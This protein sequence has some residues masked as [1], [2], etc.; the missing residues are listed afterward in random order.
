MG[1]RIQKIETWFS[2]IGKKLISGVNFAGFTALIFLSALYY[3]KNSWSKRHE[4][5]LQMYNAGVKTFPVVS[6]VAL[7]TGM[8]LALQLGVEM[9]VFQQ[10]YLVG[11]AIM[12]MLTREMGPFM[13]GIILIAS[14]GASMAAEIGTMKV[15]EEIDALELM[16][17]SPVKFLVMPRVIAMM[18]MTPIVSIYIIAIGSL[19][20][21]VVANAQLGVPYNIYY[22]HAMKGLHLKAIYVGTVKAFIFG[23]LISSISCAYGLKAVNGALGVG[24]GTRDSVVAS[25]VMVLVIG[26]IITSIFYGRK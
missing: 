12:A 20:A 18:L 1:K 16:S 23:L 15:S 8:V 4:I 19:G 9:K 6:V 10:Q 7:F 2:G 13:A 5:I 17:I 21:A 26:Y 3:M 24:K 14:M 11:H 25:F 22:F